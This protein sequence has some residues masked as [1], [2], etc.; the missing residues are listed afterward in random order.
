MKKYILLLIYP[1]L[2]NISFGQSTIGFQNDIKNIGT[3]SSSNGAVM[4][5]DGKITSESLNSQTIS[6]ITTFNNSDV[7]GARYL[8]DTWTNGNV[9]D[10]KNNIY[11][12]NYTFNFDKI[13]QDVYAKY[14]GSANISVVLDKSQI[15]RFTIGSFN[16][17]NA[18]LVDPKVKDGFY[19]ILIEDSAKVSLYKFT[20]TKFIKANPND[21]MN[22]RTGNFGSEYKDENKYFI[23]V[24]KG[25]L[26]KVTLS[27][28]SIKKALKNQSDK[29]DNYF[30]LHSSSSELDENFLIGLIRNINQ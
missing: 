22:I 30:S 10:I 15:K 21:M 11:S 12:S 6:G 25:E 20:T 27:E 7:K 28:S 2:T 23:S 1:L 17:I 29:V 26:K 24:N 4:N 19:N 14:T 18:S 13:N 9:T 5:H 3:L 8:F 16:F